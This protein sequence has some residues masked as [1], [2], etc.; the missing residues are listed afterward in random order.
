MHWGFVIAGY[1][2]V[3]AGLAV[4]TASVLF[5]GRELSKQVPEERRRFLD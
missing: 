3:F 4:Y 1:L 2:I 5:R